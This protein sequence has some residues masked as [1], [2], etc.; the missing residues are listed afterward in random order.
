MNEVVDVF[1]IAYRERRLISIIVE[2]LTLCNESCEHCYIPEHNGT[3]LETNEVIRM[4]RD[5]R[6]QGGAMI[7]FTGGEIFL[8]QD[9]WEILGAA[10]KEYLRVFILTNATLIT[11][12][13]ALRL[14]DMGIAEISTT[15]YSLRA[16]VH[17]SITKVNGSLMQTLN[18]IKNVKKYGTPVV[19]KT[20]VMEKNK[21][22][23]M[24]I[25]RFC[26]K[27][28]YGFLFSPV[29]FS[30]SNGDSSPH[31][32]A[33]SVADLPQILRNMPEQKKCYEGID[34]EHDSICRKL[35]YSLAIDQNGDAYPCN[36][37]F[38]KIGNIRENSFEEIWNNSNLQK[39]QG[40]KTKDLAKCSECDFVNECTRCPGVALLEDKTLFGCSESAK[41]IAM[42]K[43]KMR[44]KEV[45]TR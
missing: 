5:F 23:Y 17:D 32:Y 26:K 8:R 4:I 39:L 3:G 40:M 15:I 18:G 30:K 37:F 13:V 20:P 10:R 33:V 6:K 31:K 22:D 35:S 2:L 45:S 36:C 41:T 38:V 14:A 12:E 44:E 7:T 19:V 43:H 9:I 16:E 24:E 34:L 11:E 42:I 28:E 29:I 1:D 27:R 21:F 25:E